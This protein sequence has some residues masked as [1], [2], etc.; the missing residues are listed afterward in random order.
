[1]RGVRMKKMA[2]REEDNSNDWH[3]PPKG[4]APLPPLS[5]IGVY[6]SSE[7]ATWPISHPVTIKCSNLVY[8]KERQ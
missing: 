6:K 7:R 3:N 2:W 5:K 4:F 8:K 1:M